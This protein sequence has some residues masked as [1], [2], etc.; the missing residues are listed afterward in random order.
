[1]RVT[2]PTLLGLLFSIPNNRKREAPK[3]ASFNSPIISS[4]LGPRVLFS[5]LSPSTS[6]TVNNQVSDP[7]MATVKV[8]VLYRV[9]K[10]PLCTWRLQYK[11]MQKYF[12]QFQSLAMIK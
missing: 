5:I 12:K 2:C 1:M 3:Y 8:I 7:Y 6:Y 9:I 4:T 10:K 11:N